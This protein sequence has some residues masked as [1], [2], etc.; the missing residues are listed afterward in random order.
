MNDFLFETISRMV[1]SR[2]KLACQAL[3]LL[4]P[5]CDDIIQSRC[6]D[7]QIIERI[8]DKLLYLCFDERILHLFRKLCRYYYRFEFRT[9]KNQ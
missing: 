6:L 5:E 7:I 8:L 1:N 9:Q 2:N 3:V 4:K